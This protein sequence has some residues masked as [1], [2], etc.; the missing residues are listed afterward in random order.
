MAVWRFVTPGYFA[1]LGIPIV[2]GRGFTEDDRGPGEERVIVSESLARKLY[3]DGD[4]L[5]KHLT[6]EDSHLIVGIARDVKNNGAAEPSDPEYYVL[7]KNMLGPTYRNQGSPDAWRAAKLVLRTS[8]N[9]KTTSSWITREFRTLDPDLPVTV[10]TMQQRVS[11][12]AQRPRFNALLLSLFAA[13]GALLAA[14]GLYGVMAFLVGQRTQEIGI[15]IALGATP[16]HIARLILSRAALWTAAG[17]I[18]GFIGVLFATRALRSLLFQVSEHDSWTFAAA[19]FALGLI[20]VAAAWWPSR[21][22]SRVDPMSA[23]RHD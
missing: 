10:T 18:A 1:A 19:L 5:G 15:R 7:R 11:K 22:A 13:M 3:P 17:G 9:P 20:A 6:M 21:R 23:L 12:L 8:A 2:Q 14:I 4:A 16:S